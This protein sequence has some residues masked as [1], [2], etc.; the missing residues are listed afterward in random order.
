MNRKIPPTVN[1]SAPMVIGVLPMGAKAWDVPVVPHSTAALR[2]SI[3]PL[4]SEVISFLEFFIF[5]IRNFQ[6]IAFFSQGKLP[7]FWQSRAVP[8]MFRKKRFYPLQV[9]IPGRQ[10]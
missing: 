10:A 8:R 2:I 1:L 7:E 5:S 3:I 9:H 6:R 4:N